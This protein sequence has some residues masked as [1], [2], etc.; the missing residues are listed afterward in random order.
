M[1]DLSVGAPEMVMGKADVWG[2]ALDSV[3]G[4]NTTDNYAS[5]EADS[6]NLCNITDL[7]KNG[8]EGKNIRTPEKK[9]LLIPS[10]SGKRFDQEFATQL[11]TKDQLAF[12]LR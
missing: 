5:H 3:L 2:K 12:C 8:V 9:V 4:F 11:S 7:N 10:P 1:T 6:E